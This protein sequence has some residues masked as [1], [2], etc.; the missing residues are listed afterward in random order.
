MKLVILSCSWVWT[1]LVSL[2]AAV[3]PPIWQTWWLHLLGFLIILTAIYILHRLRILSIEKRRKELEKLVNERTRELERERMIA[4]AASQAK[5]D[6]LARMSHEIRTPLN[7]VIGFNEMLA[8]T[9]LNDEQ[10]DYVRTAGRSGE[11]LLKL[12]DDI[13]DFAR[14]ESGK[15]T[16]EDTAFEPRV[17][18]SELCAS[19]R[20][21]LGGKPVKLQ[22][23][24]DHDVPNFVQGDPGRFRQVLV[25]LVTNAVKFTDSGEI[26]VSLSLQEET[27]NTVTLHAKVTDTGIG[28]PPDR[29]ERVFDP[30]QQGDSSICRQYGGSGLGLPICKQISKIM[31]GDVRVESELGKGSTFHFTAVMTKLA[32]KSL[33]L[34]SASD[35]TTAFVKPSI[36]ADE[37]NHSIRILLAEDNLVNQKLVRY[38]LTKTGYEIEIVDNGKDAVKVYTTNPERFALILM[39]IQMPEMNGLDASIA[40][41]GKGFTQVPIIALTAQAMKGD[42]EKCLAAGMNDYLAKPIKQ[43]AVIETVRM[44]TTGNKS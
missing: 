19:L 21:K 25:N 9:D 20:P 43:S 32:E 37:G 34:I 35:S 7:A 22:C 15:L 24:T 17:I 29:L 36:T 42:R 26:T 10:K 3:L 6:F 31:K 5:S 8:A 2:N 13:L 18:L 27:E 39:D 4:E 38:M 1:K 40:I 41:R 12:I 44:W 23:S 30:F 11:L 33:P 28:I 14:V 16:F